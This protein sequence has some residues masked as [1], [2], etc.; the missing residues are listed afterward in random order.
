MLHISIKNMLQFFHNSKMNEADFK[1]SF[2]KNLRELRKKKGLSQEKLAELTGVT[3]KTLSYWENGHNSVTFGKIPKLAEALNVPV[4]R[5]FIFET[6]ETEN[7]ADA[8]ISQLIESDKKLA[9]DILKLF[10]A[11]D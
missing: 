4:Y 8:L 2:S 6:I 7:G 10:Q 9:I 5:L 3:P 1:K 11:K